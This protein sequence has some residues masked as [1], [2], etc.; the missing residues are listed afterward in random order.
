ME[1]L[2]RVTSRYCR[3]FRTWVVILFEAHE[4]KPQMV[5]VQL[6]ELASN[7]FGWFVISCNTDY[8]S[9]AAHRVHQKLQHLPQHIL[10]IRGACNQGIEVELPGKIFLIQ[11]AVVFPF[12]FSSSGCARQ[13]RISITQVSIALIILIPRDF[14]G[15]GVAVFTVPESCFSRFWSRASD[16]SEIKFFT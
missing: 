2:L 16:N 6:H 4:D 12:G 3:I 14:N 8:L 11:S 13:E 9:P 1:A 15:S 10:I 5:A 7:H